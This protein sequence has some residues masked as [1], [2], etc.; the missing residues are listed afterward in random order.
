M[1][2]GDRGD[3]LLQCAMLV[4]GAMVVYWSCFMDHSDDGLPG[5]PTLEKWWKRSERKQHAQGHATRIDPGVM[6]ALRTV[7]IER[8]AAGLDIPPEV[9]GMPGLADWHEKRRREEAQ[10]GMTFVEVADHQRRIAHFLRR[11]PAGQGSDIGI[12]H[13]PTLKP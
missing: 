6:L 12:V 4:F 3:A 8:L 7:A 9:L 13:D 5:D 1:F 11:R 2:A 10:L